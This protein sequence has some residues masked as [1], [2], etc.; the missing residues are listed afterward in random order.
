MIHRSHR[1]S[2]NQKTMESEDD[3]IA[4]FKCIAKMSDYQMPND[5]KNVSLLSTYNRFWDEQCMQ[6]DPLLWFFSDLFTFLACRPN[7]NVLRLYY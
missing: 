5:Q 7:W 6:Y 1:Y 4:I 2:D 3:I